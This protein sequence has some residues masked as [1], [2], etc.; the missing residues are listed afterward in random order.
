VSVLRVLIT[1]DNRDNA[2]SLAILVRLWGHEVR[3]AYDGAEAIAVSSHFQPQVVLAD[4]AMPRLNGNNLARQ[5]RQRLGQRL[6]LIAVTA[7]GLERD[8]R[9][10]RDAGFDHLMLKPVDPEAIEVLLAYS[11]GR[12]HGQMV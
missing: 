4:L 10:S 9:E 8:Y 5:L 7:Y 1:D 3:V 6:V 2:N 12:F 11:E